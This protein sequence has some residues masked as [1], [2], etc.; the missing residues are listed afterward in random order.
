MLTEKIPFKSLETSF[1]LK[2][3]FAVVAV[4][5]SPVLFAK[6]LQTPQAAAGGAERAG[7]GPAPCTAAC[8]ETPKWETEAREPPHPSSGVTALRA[9]SPL[10]QE[11]GGGT[12]HSSKSPFLPQNPQEEK[13]QRGWEIVFYLE[14]PVGTR[15]STS[16]TRGVVFPLSQRGCTYPVS[17][18]PPLSYTSLP[19]STLPSPN[20]ERCQTQSPLC[21]AC[22]RALRNGDASPKPG[23]RGRGSSGLC[24]P[25]SPALT[26]VGARSIPLQ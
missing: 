10:P 6:R 14:D 23:P 25:S 11:H 18:Q 5:S 9:L 1:C 22:C 20:T 17:I 16:H 4:F 19:H 13:Q 2:G 15:T 12:R 8:A 24:L 21:P 7:E 26:T 3:F